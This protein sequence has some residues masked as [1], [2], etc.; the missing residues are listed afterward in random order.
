MSD[1]PYPERACVFISQLKEFKKEKR[2]RM[3]GLASIGKELLFIRICK[4]N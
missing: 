4:Q 2:K 3:I 1:V